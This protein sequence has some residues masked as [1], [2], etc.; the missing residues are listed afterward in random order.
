MACGC[1][2]KAVATPQQVEQSLNSVSAST[3]PTE[4][5]T[6]KKTSQQRPLR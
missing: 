2:K 5:K 6:Q 4:D 3:E 1:G